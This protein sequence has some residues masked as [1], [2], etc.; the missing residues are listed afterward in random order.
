MSVSL[1]KGQ[2]VSLSKEQSDLSKVTLGLGWDIAS[3]GTDFDLD[4]S[5]FLLKN[6][7]LRSKND[8]VYFGNLH[9][10]S[11]AVRHMGDNLTGEGEGDDEQIKVDLLKV[12]ADYTEI[13]FAV[14][15]YDSFLR[16][17]HF[18]KVK[19]AF[20]R[21]CDNTG[22]ELYRYNLT[23]SY[24]G[25]TAVVFARLYKDENGWQFHAV[26]EGSNAKSVTDMSKQFRGTE[27]EKK[28]LFGR[29]FGR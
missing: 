28:G 6:G 26:G 11:G 19:N 29:L 15:I 17:Q 27:P 18:G 9:H 8:I 20:I 12:P 23:D 3:R 10:S 16:G 13:V 1:S 7:V 24:S 21:M 5:A 25:K 2:V 22:K 14:N 4:A